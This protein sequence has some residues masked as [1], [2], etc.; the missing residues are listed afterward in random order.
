MNGLMD[1]MIKKPCAF[2]IRMAQPLLTG[3]HIFGILAERGIQVSTMNLH[4]TSQGNGFLI[5][6]CLME[7]DRMRSM[8]HFLEKYK[9]VM[10]LE[11]LQGRNSNLFKEI[12]S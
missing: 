7:N 3:S 8:R 5:I 10:E 6:H 11:V 1:D 9:G 12:E 2:I 4:I